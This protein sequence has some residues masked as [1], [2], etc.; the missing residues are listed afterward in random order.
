MPQL[1][2]IHFRD[3]Y[4]LAVPEHDRH[5]LIGTPSY[6]TRAGAV[7]GRGSGLDVFVSSDLCAWEGPMTVFEP[8]EDFW[9]THD[10][11]APELHH[12]RGRF[13]IFCTFKASDACRGTHVLVADDVLGPYEPL[14][15]E[16]PT[17]RDW[18]CLD[19]TL[20]VDG[21]GSPWMVF[22]HEWVQVGDGE[23]CAVRLSDD[24]SRPI[25][26][27]R[28]LFTAT[29]APWVDAYPRPDCYVTDGPS[30]YRA[31]DG[32]LLM[33][34]SSFTE[35]RYAVG[36]ARS[37]SGSVEGPWEQSPTPLYDQDGGHGSVCR[38]L[39]GDLV[40]AL[41]RPNSAPSERPL[42]LPLCERDGTLV[43]TS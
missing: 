6:R 30:L 33:A 19:G 17:P 12:F 2:E 40:L 4:I 7:T 36:L 21:D 38:T 29:Q 23:M 37:A 26:Q 13:Y 42:L 39:S 14:T 25:G 1:D 16:P 5:Y 18:E 28:L 43:L 41:H 20:Y 9:G 22:C 27:P 31:S 15:D 35:G 8:P 3:P 32:S 11:W 10:F 24:L 34:W